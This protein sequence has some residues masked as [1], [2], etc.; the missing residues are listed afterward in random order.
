MRTAYRIAMAAVLAAA[1]ASCNQGPGTA[2]QP[3]L[4]GT[5]Q[6][7]SYVGGNYDATDNHAITLTIT[8][9]TYTERYDPPLVVEGVGIVAFSAKYTADAEKKTITLTGFRVETGT[10][11][12][13]GAGSEVVSYSFPE[14]DHLRLERE[15]VIL[16]A[17]RE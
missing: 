5:W 3:T 15:G 16:T 6:V 11:Q 12:I 14:Q 1:L 10:D 7:T 13:P 8:A 9:D 4:I 17:R 2:P